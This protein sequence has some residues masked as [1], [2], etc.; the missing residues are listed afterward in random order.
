[1]K[2]DLE[3]RSWRGES[4]LPW[5]RVEP[6]GLVRLF[7]DMERTVTTAH[8]S[9]PPAHAGSRGFAFPDGREVGEA[10][11]RVRVQVLSVAG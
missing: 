8:G 7:Q 1:M 2:M 11:N 5:K 3:E 4:L 9:V 6:S 10:Q